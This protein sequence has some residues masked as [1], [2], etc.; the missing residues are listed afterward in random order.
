M[1]MYWI[2]LLSKSASLLL[3]C[4]HTNPGSLNEMPSDRLIVGSQQR[5]QR[6]RCAHDSPVASEGSYMSLHIGSRQQKSVVANVFE[7]QKLKC[8]NYI[9]HA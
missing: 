7:E 5:E 1:Y 8:S 2:H 4:L 6:F 3:F 9:H